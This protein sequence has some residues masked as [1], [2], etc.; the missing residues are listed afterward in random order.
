MSETV[1]RRRCHGYCGLPIPAGK[2]NTYQVI[3]PDGTVREFCDGDCL[4][5]YYLEAS[6]DGAAQARLAALVGALER[7]ARVGDQGSPRERVDV[8]LARLSGGPWVCE[9]SSGAELE[10]ARQQASVREGSGET[11]EAAI[12]GALTGGAGGGPD[13]DLGG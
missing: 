13:D 9:I 12:T 1:A 7:A 2:L 4:G 5:T 8:V 10:P 6:R 11:I 3:G